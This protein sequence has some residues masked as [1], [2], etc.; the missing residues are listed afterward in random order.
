MTGES[1]PGSA[2]APAS[3]TSD[4]PSDRVRLSPPGAS[5]TPV[6]RTGGSGSSTRDTRVP[7]PGVG[8]STP[9]TASDAP[10]AGSSTAHNNEPSSEVPLPVATAPAARPHTRSQSGIRREK[11]YTDGTVKY[12]LFSHTVIHVR[13]ALTT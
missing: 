3:P 10:G 4:G 7:E 6:V 9:V 5:S 12:G 8:S 1:A 2:S 11:V 13:E